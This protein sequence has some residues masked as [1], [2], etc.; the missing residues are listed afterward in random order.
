MNRCSCFPSFKLEETKE[1]KRKTKE[2]KETKTDKF[3]PNKA[4]R[5]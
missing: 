5:N 4:R 1:E 3:G 2:K